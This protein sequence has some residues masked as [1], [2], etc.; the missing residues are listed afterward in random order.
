LAQGSHSSFVFRV[1]RETIKQF[2]PQDRFVLPPA[3][4]RENFTH[5]LG[6]FGL[7]RELREDWQQPEEL[8]VSFLRSSIRRSNNNSSLTIF[9]RQQ[10]VHG[11]RRST[12][13]R[14]SLSNISNNKHVRERRTNRM[15]RTWCA[16]ES[17]ITPWSVRQALRKAM[18]RMCAMS[19]D[20][21]PDRIGM[22]HHGGGRGISSSNS[23]SS[24]MYC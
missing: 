12:T 21:H 8:S 15:V 7:R 19:R 18:A 2:V 20:H 3:D 23:S 9:V 13:T 1:E 6:K 5:G 4:E 17:R 11:I 10:V 24:S 14:P 22:D 16:R